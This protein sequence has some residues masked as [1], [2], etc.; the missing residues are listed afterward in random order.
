MWFMFPQMKGLG[1]SHTSAMFG[2]SSKEEAE[3]YLGHSILGRRLRDCTQ[4]VMNIKDQSAHDIFGYPDDLKFR[5]CMT[6]FAAVSPRDGIFRKA[7]QKYFSGTPDQRTL[8]LLKEQS[9]SGTRG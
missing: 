3:A 5:S 8:D 6:L 9:A 2:I 4:L 7:I 1:F